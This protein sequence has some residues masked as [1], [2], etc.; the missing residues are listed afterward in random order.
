MRI[1][2]L[3]GLLL[4]L[5]LLARGMAI[6]LHEESAPPAPAG[7]RQTAVAAGKTG[8]AFYPPVPAELLDLN[9]GYIFNEAR[10]MSRESRPGKKEAEAVI[11]ISD[12]SYV[13]SAISSERRIGI[14][15]YPEPAAGFSHVAGRVRPGSRPAGGRHV[16]LAPGE[17]F[18]GYLVADVLPDRIVFEKDGIR[19]EKPL[20]RREPSKTAPQLQADRKPQERPFKGTI[21]RSGRS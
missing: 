17:T 12:I 18:S 2:L 1:T 9:P 6:T 8:F 21:I 19:I 7:E 10:A 5:L 14:I 15:S 4:S 3:A 16:H 13:G 11:A 20:I